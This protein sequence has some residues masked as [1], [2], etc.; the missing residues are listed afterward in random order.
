MKNAYENN[1]PDQSGSN[2]RQLDRL[3]SMVGL[4]GRAVIKSDS[5]SVGQV[6]PNL[7]TSVKNLRIDKAHLAAYQTLM[8]F[9]KSSKLPATYLSMLGFPTALEIMTDAKFP[10]KAMGQ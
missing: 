1:A 7:A 4:F 9:N 3:P 10:M 8:G 6:L 2:Y 5:F